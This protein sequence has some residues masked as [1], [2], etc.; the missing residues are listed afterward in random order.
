MYFIIFL[1]LYDR[2]GLVSADPGCDIVQDSSLPYPSCCPTIRCDAPVLQ[3]DSVD[4]DAMFLPSNNI[5]S[6]DINEIDEWR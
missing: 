6:N 1:I 3:Y 5:N 4:Y 2:C